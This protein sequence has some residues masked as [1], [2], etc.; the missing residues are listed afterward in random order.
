MKAFDGLQAADVVVS[1]PPYVS[2][3]E[4]E[5]LPD[6]IRLFEPKEAL[7]AGEDGLEH[8]RRLIAAAGPRLKPGSSLLVEIG[9]S[10]ADKVREIFSRAGCYVEV[11][12]HPDLGRI[13]R[14]A[15]ARKSG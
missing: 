10:Q 11:E 3:S 15:V 9:E 2:R 8:L 4:W 6:E 14:V 5:G 7:C 12:V 1:N 13:E